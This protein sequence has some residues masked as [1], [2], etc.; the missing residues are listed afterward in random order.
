MFTYKLNNTVLKDADSHTYL[1]VDISS[2][3][4]W[5]SHINRIISKANK[6][7]GFLR[8][9][10][11]SCSKQIKEMAYKSLVRPILECSS[12]LWD[13]HVKSL[14]K[15]LEAVQNRAARFVSGV[16]SRKSNITSVKQELIK[17]D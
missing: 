4:T 3:L 7:L 8:R 12:P 11:Y 17:M 1:G 14:A 15:Q 16:Y 9:N 5:N 6:S 10:L 13:P 2:D